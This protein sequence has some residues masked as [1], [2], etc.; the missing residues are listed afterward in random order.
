MTLFYFLLNLISYYDEDLKFFFDTRRIFVNFNYY[1][2]NIDLYTSTY[3]E[4]RE[5]Y[6]LDDFNLDNH[7]YKLIYIL[8]F[9]F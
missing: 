2:T 7:K 6:D 8:F 4:K 1:L 9:L 3:N 5:D